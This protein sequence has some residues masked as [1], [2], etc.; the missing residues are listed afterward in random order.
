VCCVAVQSA[1]LA[2]AWLCLTFGIYC[3]RLPAVCQS[4]PSHRTLRHS[5]W[6]VSR[7]GTRC[8]IFLRNSGVGRDGFKRVFKTH[9]TYTEAPGALDDVLYKSTFNLHQ[10]YYIAYCFLSSIFACIVK[11]NPS[12]SQF[13]WRGLRAFSVL[14]P[15]LWIELC[16]DCCVTLATTLLALDILWRHFCRQ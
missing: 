11:A 9:A 14:G 4:L 6:L 8:L 7:S 5:L 16:L 10:I 12:S 1:I 2:T 3:T 13:P 15:R